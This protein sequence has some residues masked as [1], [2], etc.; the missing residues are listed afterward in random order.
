[1]LHE[2]NKTANLDLHIDLGQL[3]VRIDVQNNLGFT[4]IP[5]KNNITVDGYFHPHVRPEGAI[6]WGEASTAAMKNIANL[7]LEKA[8]RLLHSLLNSYN[9]A[10]P[11]VQLGRFKVD[12]N[13]LTRVADHLKH[14]DKRKKAKEEGIPGI[15]TAVDIAF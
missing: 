2:V 13:K 9:G 6:C 10:S 11:Y 7:E 15:A 8:L 1:M 5:Y 3:A 14:P 12:G 4:V